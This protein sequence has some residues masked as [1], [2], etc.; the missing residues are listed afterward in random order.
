MS[1]AS[2][3]CDA[4]KFNHLDDSSRTDERHSD[5]VARHNELSEKAT[6]AFSDCDLAEKLREL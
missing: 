1:Q 3:I 2:G 6:P 4:T 5:T